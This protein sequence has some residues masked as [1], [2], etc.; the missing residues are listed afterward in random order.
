MSA[1]RLQ[2]DPIACTA[3]G[4]CA[5]LLPELVDLDEWGY[6][7]LPATAVPRRLTAAAA[8]AVANC[9]ALALRLSAVPGPAERP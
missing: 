6:P 8:R 3:H 1:R 9:P 2:V 7:V 5:E 4:I